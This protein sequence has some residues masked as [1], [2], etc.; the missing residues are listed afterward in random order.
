MKLNWCFN[1]VGA[2]HVACAREGASVRSNARTTW[3]QRQHVT[4]HAHTHQPADSSIN[5]PRERDARGNDDQQLLLGR[6][7]K[8]TEPGRVLA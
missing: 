4:A 3:S 2:R 7:A 1:H 6:D 8:T 5:N